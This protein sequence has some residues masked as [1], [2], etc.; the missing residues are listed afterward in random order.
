MLLGKE[1]LFLATDEHGF[2]PLM[3]DFA[4]ILFTLSPYMSCFAMKKSAPEILKYFQK[5]ENSML[6]WHLLAR[7]YFS[8]FTVFP[9]VHTCTSVRS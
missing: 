4:S 1:F 5:F 7:R 9:K 8:P 2:K 6:N 3:L